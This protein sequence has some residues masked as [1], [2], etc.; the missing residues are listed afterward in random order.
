MVKYVSNNMM[1]ILLL[2]GTGAMGVHLAQ[3]L[4]DRSDVEYVYVTSRSVRADKG[5]IKYLVG[6]AKDIN[7]LKEALAITQ[8]DCIV[9]FMTYTS[10]EL[11]NRISLLLSVCKQYIFL[12]S[13]RCYADSKEKITE[14]TPYLVDAIKD[15]TYLSTKEYGLEKGRSEIIVKQS[16][17]NWTIIRPYITYSEDRLQL[18]VYEKEDWLYRA[19][20]GRTIV[21]SK[22]IADK[23]T[24]LTYGLDVARGISQL[25]GVKSAIEQEF[26]IT[27][28]ES[29]R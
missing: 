19:L 6:N 2:G 25:I 22:D 21:F 5:R 10:E 27:Q 9:D 4:N 12:S 18:G 8:W 14:K 24:T 11:E 17:T 3:L 1:R 7:F 23:F 20:H 28:T 16:G 26:H 13:A 29:V 15:D